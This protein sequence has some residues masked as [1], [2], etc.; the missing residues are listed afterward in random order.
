MNDKAQAFCAEVQALLRQ[1]GVDAIEA[2]GPHGNNQFRITFGGPD[3]L[4][5]IQLGPGEEVWVSENDDGRHIYTSRQ[6]P[7]MGNLSSVMKKHGVTLIQ[8]IAVSAANQG[9]AFRV[10][11]YAMEV[12]PELAAITQT[13]IREPGPVTRDGT[14]PAVLATWTVK[15]GTAKGQPTETR[16][17]TYTQPDYDSDK[18]LAEDPG[19]EFPM[20]IAS[21]MGPP[22]NIFTRRQYDSFYWAWMS[23]NPGATNWAQL[24]FIWTGTP[25]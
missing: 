14:E 3:D 2:V 24:E 13:E 17:W 9:L 15:R 21:P 22:H 4:T 25:S 23:P 7:F 20:S 16:Q 11:F 10:D 1:H 6:Q 18:A 19:G 12:D 8:S 5:L